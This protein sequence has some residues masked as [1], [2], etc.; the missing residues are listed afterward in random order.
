MMKKSNLIL[1]KY[2]GNAM[3]SERL[4]DAVVKNIG[5]LQADG[6]RVVLVHGGGPFIQRILKTVRIK[7]EF[8]EGHRKTS[9]EALKYIEMALKGEVNGNLVNLL[10][11]AGLKAVGLSGKDGPLAV[12]EKRYHLK[13]E[14]GQQQRYDLGQVGD[15][16]SIDTSLVLTLLDNGYLPVVTCIASDKEGNDYN[17]NADMFA[18]HLAGALKVDHYLIL[19]DVDGLL[20]NLNDP[21]SRIDR[22]P[23]KEMSGLFGNVI[24]GG[25]IPKL[26]S[27]QI[28][29][30]AGA[31]S[32]CIINGTRPATIIEAIYSEKSIGT[33]ICL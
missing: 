11:R 18:G 3:Q 25:M 8:I 30:Q 12:A 4:K 13:T 17:I 24:T 16:K 20:R 23:I 26:E 7:S 27:C 31:K 10:N 19:T 29:L 21:E 14:N 32:T 1:I 5:K 28:A 15:V 9:P 33:E 22:M 2:G 6:H